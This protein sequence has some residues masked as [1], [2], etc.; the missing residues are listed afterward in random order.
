MFLFKSFLKYTIIKVKLL[1]INNYKK[2]F[3]L[4]EN[5]KNKT[6]KTSNNR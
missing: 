2:N 5:E 6:Q 1:I 4:N 3:S